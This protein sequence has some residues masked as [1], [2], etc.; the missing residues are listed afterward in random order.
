M[1]TTSI[2]IVEDNDILED[3]KTLALTQRANI[4]LCPVLFRQ[5]ISLFKS[6]APLIAMS[7]GFKTL[8][9]ALLGNL[10]RLHLWGATFDEGQLKAILAESEALQSTILDLTFTL[11]KVLV[12]GKIQ[13][14]FSTRTVLTLPKIFCPALDKLLLVSF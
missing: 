1:E 12:E 8:S 13:T 4:N 6:S 11:S 3:I 2:E 5:S 10:G 9:R 14:C 7:P